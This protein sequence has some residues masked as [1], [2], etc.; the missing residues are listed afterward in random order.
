MEQNEVKLHGEAMIFPIEKIP[1][2]A[3]RIKPSHKKHHIIA[4][5]EQ[6]GNHHVVG[7]K[8]D[9]EFFMDDDG[10]MFM[11]AKSDTDVSCVIDKRHTSMGL[12]AGTY[13]FGIQKEYDHFAENH[14]NVRD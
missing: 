8:E 4:D 14:R 2:G 11:K 5:S 3:K 13:G 9:T 12:P 7:V 6:T 1:E 10:N